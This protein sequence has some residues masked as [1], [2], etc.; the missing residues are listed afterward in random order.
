MALSWP[1]SLPEDFLEAGY[2]EG[3][4][5]NTIR[6]SDYGGFITEVRRRS[7]A[8]PFPVAGEMVMDTDQWNI[9]FAYFS[10]LADGAL[11][12]NLPAQGSGSDELIDWVCRFTEPPTRTY[13]AL[14]VWR[15]AFK[16]EVLDSVVRG[17]ISPQQTFTSVN[18]FFTPTVAIFNTDFTL[19]AQRYNDPDT[20]T[21]TFVLG[22]EKLLEPPLITDADLFYAPSVA[23]GVRAI[24]PARYNDTDTF[25]APTIQRGARTLTPTLITDADT[26]Y[27]PTIITAAGQIFPARVTDPDTFYTTTVLQA[28]ILTPA[29]YTDADNFYAPTVARGAR[30]LTPAL[31][32]D[33]D[34]VYA[35]TMARGT[36]T[37]TPA[38]YTDA[39]TFYAPSVTVHQDSLLLRDGVSYLLLRDGTSKLLLGH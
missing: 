13:L 11:T 12:F 39:D 6:S 33:T 37:L 21:Q 23:R 5:E 38:L 9:F 24:S 28:V 22:D 7:T 19:T 8:S 4:A 26:F 36:R 16:I 31:Y 3:L 18:T 32:S 14:D 35:P 15:V 27:D 2:A 34:T 25:Y 1:G 17:E 30:T 29:L 10:E 20:F